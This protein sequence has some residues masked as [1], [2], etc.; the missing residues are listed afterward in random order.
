[1]YLC[2]SYIGEQSSIA[3]NKENEWVHG[4]WVEITGSV[5]RLSFEGKLQRKKIRAKAVEA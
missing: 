5:Y 2:I 4:D 3:E 1:M